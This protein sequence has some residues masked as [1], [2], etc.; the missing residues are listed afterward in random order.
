MYHFFNNHKLRQGSWSWW[1]H[2]DTRIKRWPLPRRHDQ[3]GGCRTAR[4]CH[5]S[6]SVFIALDHQAATENRGELSTRHAVCY[7][8]SSVCPPHAI[9][10]SEKWTHSTVLQARNSAPILKAQ[11]IEIYFNTGWITFS[12]LI[13]IMTRCR[14]SPKLQCQRDRR[15]WFTPQSVCWHYFGHHSASALLALFE[16]GA[17]SWRVFPW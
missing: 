12:I 8:A 7:Q 6:L 10:C 15:K 2:L 11:K 9:V 5:V 13:S 4:H 17:F 14:Q 1:R 16:I 3:R